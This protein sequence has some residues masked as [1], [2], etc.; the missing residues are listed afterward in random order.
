[1]NG[2]IVAHGALTPVGQS[3]TPGSDFPI[4]LVALSGTGKMAGAVATVLQIAVCKQGHGKRWI[5]REGCTQAWPTAPGMVDIYGAGLCIDHARWEACGGEILSLHLH[6]Q[7][8]ASLMPTDQPLLALDT[9]FALRN[10]AIAQLVLALWHET[11]HHAPHGLL[12]AQG[13]SLALIGALLARQAPDKN[14]PHA[15]LKTLLA[16]DR[17]R[18]QTM[19]RE[20][21]AED[22]SIE[23]LSAA[24]S[25]SPFHFAKLFKATFGQSPHA[26]VLQLRIEAA[27]AALRQQ[28]DESIADIA[29]QHGFSSQSHF[30]T[31]FRKRMGTTP[32]LW[33]QQR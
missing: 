4:Q 11:E 21:L 12:Y 23:R 27:S 10:P 24:I 13:L 5:T 32:A 6:P 2:L 8:I 25:I 17:Q 18:L 7:A 20:H 15:S 28:S 33:R 31:A 30:T 22:L 1:M 26:Y 19:I 29:S 3:T 16:R 14:L 9:Q